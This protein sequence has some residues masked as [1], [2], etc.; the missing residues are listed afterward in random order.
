MRKNSCFVN[1]S[2]ACCKFCRV[3][4]GIFSNGADYIADD[5]NQFKL[6]LDSDEAKEAMQFVTDQN[7]IDKVVYEID[8]DTS[9]SDNTQS[10]SGK[11][12]SLFLRNKAA[13]SVNDPGSSDNFE[14]GRVYYPKGPNAD[15]YI[16]H[17]TAGNFYGIP[18]GTEDEKA[19]AVAMANLFSYFDTTKN[20]SLMMNLVLLTG[21]LINLKIYC[22]II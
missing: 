17:Q 4:G 8:T 2:N 5:G 10:S 14:K 9:D 7:N 11:T 3:Q 15:D 20:I 1:V 12:G 18:K 6:V 19:V 13:F 16:V 22:K 21:I